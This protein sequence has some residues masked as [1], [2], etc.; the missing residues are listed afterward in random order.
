MYRYYADE[1]PSV[2]NLYLKLQHWSRDTT[3]YGD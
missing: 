2:K 3:Y 1:A